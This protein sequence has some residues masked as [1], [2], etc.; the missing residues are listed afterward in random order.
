MTLLLVSRADEF[1]HRSVGSQ[2][3]RV[4]QPMNGRRSE[5]NRQRIDTYFK[6]VF[7]RHPLDRL[8]SAF[9]EKFRLVPEYMHSYG[10]RIIRQ[11]RANATTESLERGDD[12]TLEEFVR[13]MVDTGLRFRKDVHWTSQYKL[14]QPCAI[15]YDFIG[16]YETLWSDGDYVLQ[17]LGINSD[18]RFPRWTK[19]RTHN[20]PYE[21]AYDSVRPEY[22]KRLKKLYSRDYEFFGYT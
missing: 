5:R 11:Y 2:A 21:S 13:F 12:V 1:Q 9:R 4:L 10:R 20:Q 15:S 16:H 18:V 3:L 14:C 22:M 8:L 17:R 6:F 7:V 19:N